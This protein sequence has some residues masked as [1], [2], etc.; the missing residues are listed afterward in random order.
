MRLG[1]T[2]LA[3]AAGCDLVAGSQTPPAAGDIYVEG[4]QELP[5]SVAGAAC[6]GSRECPLTQICV[7]NEC[8]YRVTSITGEALAVSAHAQ[9]LTGDL[10]T[11]ERTYQEAIAA[12][13]AGEARVPPDVA[14]G[15][16]L[17]AMRDLHEPEKRENAA[18]LS[19]RC[20]RSSLPSHAMRNEVLRSM[21][22]LRFDGLDLAAFDAEEPAAA[23]FTL[24]PSRP[25][26]DAVEIGIDIADTEGHGFEAVRDLLRSEEAKR[27]IADCFFQDWELR[28]EREAQ[29][30]L[31]LGLETRLRDMG[32]YDVYSGVISVQQTTVT[33]DGFEPCVAGA[34]TALFEEA[35]P[36]IGRSSRWQAPFDVV[37]QLQ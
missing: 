3:F 31:V 22:R 16:A 6:S 36:R 15:A 7:S 9:R 19:D 21:S 5:E 32:D 10:T 23:F 37:A 13:E 28:H 11:A 18:R 2:I 34:M 33:P 4:D 29:A 26:V 12:Y 14:C 30:S 17:A 8:R 27:S 24:E 25:T 35:S 20:F 1:W